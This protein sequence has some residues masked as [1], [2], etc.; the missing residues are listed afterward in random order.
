MKIIQLLTLNSDISTAL[1]IFLCHQIKGL[2][3]EKIM[4]HLLSSGFSE[5][6][7]K[8]VQSA[9]S[10]PVAPRVRHLSSIINIFTFN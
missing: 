4:I 5:P 2:D 6:V 3:E 1:K 10:K 8:R 7:A 9:L